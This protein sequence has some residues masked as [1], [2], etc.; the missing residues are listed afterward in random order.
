MIDNIA[1]KIRQEVFKMACNANGGHIASAFSIADIIAELYF[2]KILR[3]DAKKPQWD[4]RDIF[5]LSKGHGVLALY[6]ALSMAGFFPKEE[7]LTYCR[8]GTKLGGLAKLGSVP[9]IEATTG[10]LG[11]GL[12]FGVGIA[13]ANKVNKSTSKVYVLL[14]DGECEEGS[15]WEAFMSIIHHSLKNLITIIDYN[16]LQAMDSLE[17]IM[18][19]KGLTKRLEAFGFLV[20]NING[21]NYEEIEKV[22]KKR[23]CDK[24]KVII[25]NTVKGKGISFMENVPIWHYRIPNEEEM[26]IALSELNLTSKEIKYH[27]KC[28]FRNII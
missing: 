15:V 10:S 3:Y 14:G 27:E 23:D 5:I 6:A 13:L 9:G 21:H 25:A 7:L 28:L 18:S 1:L 24:P 2:N 20:E 12:S 17:N 16:K 26:K 8:M 22:L 11:H 4:N 19:I